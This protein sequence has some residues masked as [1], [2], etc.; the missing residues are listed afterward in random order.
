MFRVGTWFKVKNIL[1]YTK[2]VMP[3]KKTMQGSFNLYAECT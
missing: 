2:L 3:L 1:L